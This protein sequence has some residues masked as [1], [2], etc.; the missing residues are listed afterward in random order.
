MPLLLSILLSGILGTILFFIPFG[1]IVAGAI[2]A[3]V[4]FRTLYLVSDI[5]K[6]ISTITEKPDKAKEVYENYLKEKDD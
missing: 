4:L 2:I 6:R 5:H 3:G 1:Y